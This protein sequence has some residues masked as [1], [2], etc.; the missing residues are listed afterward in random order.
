MRINRKFFQ[1]EL[2]FSS[3]RCVSVTVDGCF[4]CFYGEIK[5]ELTVTCAAVLLLN[6]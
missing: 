6:D 3:T 5:T 4:M 1:S 2:F